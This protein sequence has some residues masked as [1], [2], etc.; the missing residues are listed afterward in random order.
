MSL[1]TCAAFRR[2]TALLLLVAWLFA[3]ASGVAHA[4][5]LARPVQDLAHHRVDHG[6]DVAHEAPARD[7]GAPCKKF[8]ADETSTLAKSHDPASADGTLP[9]MQTAAWRVLPEPV[10]PRAHRH[11]PPP[12]PALPVAIRFLRLTI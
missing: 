6:A 3:L 8:C 2:R 11:G 7:A 5:L 1:F 10:R 4:C 12:R 9:A